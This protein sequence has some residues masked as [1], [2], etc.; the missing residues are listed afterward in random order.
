M[1]HTT[2]A[3]P[4]ELKVGQFAGEFSRRFSGNSALRSFLLTL[5]PQGNVVSLVFEDGT[6]GWHSRAREL[7]SA[8]TAHLFCDPLGDGMEYL[9][10]SWHAIEQSVMERLIDQGFTAS[11]FQASAVF[12]SRAKRLDAAGAIPVVVGRD[13]LRQG[14][15]NQAPHLTAAAC[16]GSEVRSSPRRGR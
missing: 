9:W 7:E 6:T 1:P 5:D 12:A 13:V 8:G 2:H 15:S 3:Y 11:D 10:L 16:S 14:R 4:F